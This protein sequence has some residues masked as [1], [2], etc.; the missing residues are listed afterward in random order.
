MWFFYFSNS[1]GRCWGTKSRNPSRV[2]TG[3]QN[4][5]TFQGR[6]GSEIVGD[7]NPF[8]MTMIIDEAP[9]N[10]HQHCIKKTDMIAQGNQKTTICVIFC[11]SREK[12]IAEKFVCSGRLQ[13]TNASLP[14]VHVSQ[15]PSAIGEN[16][17]ND[18]GVCAIILSLV[19]SAV[20]STVNQLW[21]T[22]WL[23]LNKERLCQTYI[24]PKHVRSSW[25]V[26]NTSNPWLAMFLRSIPVYHPNQS[27]AQNI[28]NPWTAMFLR[29]ILAYHPSQVSLKNNS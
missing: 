17:K 24:Y 19:G 16:F 2:T 4:H 22:F 8:S 7:E 10:V 27:F 6:R 11:P 14:Q 26:Q 13:S 15:M 28:S 9:P 23:A 29:R 21:R 5:C 12:Q 1:D 25:L 20:L 18:E 3:S